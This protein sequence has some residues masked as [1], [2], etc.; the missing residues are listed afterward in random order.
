MKSESMLRAVLVV[1]AV[2]GA[3][4]ALA[5]HS[6]A[7]EFDSNKPITFTGTVQKVMWMNPHIYTHIEVKQ[8]DGSSFVYHVEVALLFGT[9]VAIGPLVRRRVPPSQARPQR[10]EAL[11]S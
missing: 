9:L 7:A 2:F 3:G 10:Y 8:A 4:G 1:C 5:H 6:T 11:H